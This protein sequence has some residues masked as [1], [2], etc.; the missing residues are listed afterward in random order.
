MLIYLSIVLNVILLIALTV[1]IF[2]RKDESNKSKMSEEGKRNVSRLN[3]KPVVVHDK[4]EETYTTYSSGVEAAKKL[5]V[6]K[7]YLYNS[8]Y[9]G[10]LI[11]GRYLITNKEEE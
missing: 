11:K 2:K 1:M 7:A 6:T 3:S 8:K 10:N 4:K 9:T 5:G